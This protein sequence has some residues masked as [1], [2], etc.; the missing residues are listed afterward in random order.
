MAAASVGSAPPGVRVGSRKPLQVHFG[1]AR[2]G[3]NR[4]RPAPPR[5]LSFLT[6][7]IAHLCH[8]LRGPPGA[9]FGPLRPAFQALTTFGPAATC[10]GH[11]ACFSLGSSPRRCWRE[12]SARL[13]GIHTR[14]V[15]RGLH[16]KRHR[17]S[18]PWGTGREDWVQGSRTSR[19]EGVAP[20]RWPLAAWAL[21]ALP[22]VA[23]DTECR[24]PLSLRASSSL[25]LGCPP[26]LA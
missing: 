14:L 25:S 6:L 12:R 3:G 13:S 2:V 16:P 24:P 15:F 5:E 23:K 1:A 11:A 22:L 18:Q 9:A 21:F 17:F 10:W 26:L 20:G 8:A 4:L 7:R 19:C